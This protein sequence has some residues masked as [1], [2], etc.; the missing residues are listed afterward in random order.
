MKKLLSVM[1]LLFVMGLACGGQEEVATV[2]PAGTLPATSS[3]VASPTMPPSATPLPLA[4][5][6]L[7]PSPTAEAAEAKPTLPPATATTP[8]PTAIGPTI[9]DAPLSATGPWLV[10]ASDNGLYAVNP[11]GSGFSQ[12]EQANLSRSATVSPDG[13]FLA[14]VVYD[15][16]GFTGFTNLTLRLLDTADLSTSIIGRLTN[17]ETEPTD[18]NQCPDQPNCNVTE[19]IGLAGSLAWSPD[20]R[21]LAFVAALDGPSSDLYLYDTND[22]QMTRLTSGP[23]QTG[24]LSWSP[25]GRFIIHE[26][27]ELAGYYPDGLWA[28]AADGSTIVRLV[29][30]GHY[31][32]M[33]GWL[34]AENFVFY[35]VEEA[36]PGFNLSKVNVISGV[37]TPLWQGFVGDPGLDVGAVNGYFVAVA[38]DPNSGALVI[39][40][41]P[42]FSAEAGYYLLRPGATSPELVALPAIGEAESPHLL[43]LPLLGGFGLAWEQSWSLME[44]PSGD[45]VSS[46]W[47]AETPL[48]AL[49]NPAQSWYAWRGDDG[50]WVAAQGEELPWQISPDPARWLSWSPAGT[51]LFL[52]LR[53][54][55]QTQLHLAPSPDFTP[56]PIAPHDLGAILA[57]IWTQK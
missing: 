27:M 3:P 39:E 25:D 30:S 13:R 40:M 20:G 32:E 55:G 43:W 6:T 41:D 18:L 45:L 14:Y 15:E 47:P 53:Q 1:L 50:V 10:M 5:E 42:Y 56:L 54:D 28:V 38:M 48:F 36:V 51:T 16:H 31:Y 24:R 49:P 21:L 19:A 44:S 7:P 23:N 11:D 29:D 17:A 35:E 52:A 9:P 8:P 12:L 57:T 33:V 22:G 4:T 37:V 26:S 46:S 34:D 2:V